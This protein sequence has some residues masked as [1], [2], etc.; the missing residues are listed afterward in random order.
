MQT[1]LASDDM[2][3]VGIVDPDLN[4]AGDHSTG[5]ISAA[6]FHRYMAVIAAGALGA[7]ATL[8]AKIE[9][10]TDAAGADAKDVDGKAITQMTA[11]GGDSDKQAI[12]NLAPTELD[13]ANNFSHFRV[14]LTIAT[15]SSD[16]GVVV[17]GHGPRYAPASERDLASVAE[18][19]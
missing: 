16:S 6:D 7:S 15:A 19:V 8:D 10:A 3:V 9:Q 12:I 5:W 17:I 13:I 4:T 14:T 11:A 2:A 18:I 1:I